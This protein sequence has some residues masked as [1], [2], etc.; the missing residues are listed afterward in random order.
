MIDAQE[1]QQPEIEAVET[2]AQDNSWPDDVE[3]AGFYPRFYALIVDMIVLM[4]PISLVL[5]QFSIMLWGPLLSQEEIRQFITQH[6]NEG[7]YIIIKEQMG[8]RLK[9]YLMLTAV[10]AATWLTCWYY[11]SA[12]PGKYLFRLKIVD[13]QTGEPASMK[14][15]V[16][17]FLGSMLSLIT[18]TFGFLW[19]HFNKK[20]RTLHDFI[21]GTVVVKRKTLPASLRDKTLKSMKETTEG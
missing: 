18:L 19:L 15:N 14:Q 4:I 1:E 10:C 21:A 7:Y 6:G 3:Y 5:T 20:R 11:L 13:A 9:E 8:R 2:E 12:T 16:L 17:R